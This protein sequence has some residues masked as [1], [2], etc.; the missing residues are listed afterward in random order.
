MTN[1]YLR[2]NYKNSDW[3]NGNTPA[4]LKNLRGKIKK[5]DQE[6]YFL[7]DEKTALELKSGTTTF[8][9]FFNEQAE[10]IQ[11][12]GNLGKSI[13]TYKN[14]IENKIAKW[15]WFDETGNLIQYE[16][17]EYSNNSEFATFFYIKKVDGSEQSIVLTIETLNANSFIYHGRYFD[18]LYVNNKLIESTANYNTLKFKYAYFD[19][20]YTKRTY[21]NETLERIEK[22]NKY[23][24]LI[25]N[26]KYDRKGIVTRKEIRKYDKNN[27]LVEIYTS[28][29]DKGF[30]VPEV[31]IYNDI[32]L[33]VE[34]K[35]LSED[36]EFYKA[37]HYEYDLQRNL[38][39]EKGDWNNAKFQ[40]KYDE[41][42]NWIEKLEIKASKIICR[43]TR[44]IEYYD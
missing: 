9:L 17:Y 31:F 27:N 33:L 10:I 29:S 15:E 35:K 13:I 43:T 20:Y 40:Y 7:N 16:L 22:F 18:E 28:S 4:R 8:I 19:D 5:L 42:D 32:D 25:E 1:D 24:F 44:E 14:F 11:E 3:F 34:M 2:R 6:E 30:Q 39:R 36:F 21:I 12:I 23:D 37:R 41:I 26:I 38:I